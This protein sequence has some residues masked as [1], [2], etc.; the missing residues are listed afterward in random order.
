[1]EARHGMV[2]AKEGHTWWR[3][4]RNTD[5]L[6]AD[7]KLEDRQRLI[8]LTKT[9]PDDGDGCASSCE[10]FQGDDLIEDEFDDKIEGGAA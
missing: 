10:P 2:K 5:Q 8:Y 1:M 3:K 6:M 7:A 9:N 4:K